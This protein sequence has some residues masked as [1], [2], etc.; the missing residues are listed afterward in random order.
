MATA[1]FGDR[2]TLQGGLRFE[3]ID[4]QYRAKELTLDEE[5]DPAG[6]V[7]VRGD[8]KSEELLPM[9]N[10]RYQLNENANLRAALTRT[11]ARPNFS[12]LAPFQLLAEEDLEIA[13]GNPNL[14]V[15][16]SWNADLLFEHYFETVGVFSAGVFY[17][18]LAD[19][20]FL[21]NFDETRAGELFEVT[22]PLNGEGAEVLGA[23]FA[24]QNQFRH[25]PGLWK[26]LGIYMN[27]TFADSEATYPE[28]DPTRLQG[29]A[30][31][32]GNLAVSY[33]EAGFTGR[34]SVNYQGDLILS[35]GSLASR[36]QILDTRTQVDLSLRQQIT[37]RFSL[38]VEFLNLTDEPYRIYEGFSDRTIQEEIYSWT[39]TVTA[40]IDF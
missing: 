29:Q 38:G 15:T 9:V 11:L 20:I 32:V 10:L 31:P 36:D 16:T 21:F 37:Q 26:G 22:Q 12:D 19:N 39:G 30:D 24:Y 7:T 25:L 23:E 5:G 33:E 13:R 8:R 27:A 6:L 14:D 4:S 34:V 40:K 18:D 17:K 28:R 3:Q 35:P 2:L 1:Y